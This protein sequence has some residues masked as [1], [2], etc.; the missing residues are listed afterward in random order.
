M[1]T[2][3]DQW[4]VAASSVCETKMGMEGINIHSFIL[5][6]FLFDVS[7]MTGNCQAFVLCLTAKAPVIL[8]CG[9]KDIGKSTFARYLTNTFLNRYKFKIFACSI[10]FHVLHN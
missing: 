3:P 10:F 2:V 1:L 8:I 5:F 9:G 7:F 6:Y 4:K